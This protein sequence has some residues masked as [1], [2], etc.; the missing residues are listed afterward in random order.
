MTKHDKM[1]ITLSLL[2]A[3]VYVALLLGIFLYN[4]NFLRHSPLWVMMTI[5]VTIIPPACANF[6]RMRHKRLRNDGA[7]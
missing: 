6:L 5:V 1:M 7:S 4:P 3:L 2:P